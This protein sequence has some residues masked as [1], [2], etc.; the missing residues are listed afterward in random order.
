MDGPSSQNV[1]V[2][3]TERGSLEGRLW[4]RRRVRKC[5]TKPIVIKGFLWTL[6]LILGLWG[7]VHPSLLVTRISGSCPSTCTCGCGMYG[8]MCPMMA[9]DAR[10][11]SHAGKTCDAGR[12]RSGLSCSCSLSH[13]ATSPRASS[14][15]ELFFNLPQSNLPFQLPLAAEHAS[16][17]FTYLPEPVK[18]LP[19]PPPRAFSAL[20]RGQFF[21]D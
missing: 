16:R 4:T 20:N 15:A 17:D 19:D 14:H 21:N 11:E 6:L 1:E 12:P 13:P 2:D 9:K 7:S 10:M 18:R 5:Y 3:A 8:G